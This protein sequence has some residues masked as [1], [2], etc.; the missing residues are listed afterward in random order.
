MKYLAVEDKTTIQ[1]VKHSERRY[2]K[3]GSVN[4]VTKQATR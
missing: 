4:C 1:N 3:L 2:F